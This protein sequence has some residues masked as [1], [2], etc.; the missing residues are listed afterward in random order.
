MVTQ[1]LILKVLYQ[2][3][4]RKANTSLA[5]IA[6]ILK[7]DKNSICS[8]FQD[9][10][11]FGLVDEKAMKNMGIIFDDL[12]DKEIIRVVSNGLQKKYE[13]SE[14]GLYRLINGTEN[15]DEKYY[16]SVGSPG[17]YAEE[18]VK[19]TDTLLGI[20][21]EI[22]KTENKMY[23]DVTDSSTGIDYDDILDI[24]NKK[25]I[26]N[27]LK[28]D[29]KKLESIK[30]SPYFGRM[31]LIENKSNGVEVLQLYIGNQVVKLD[32]NSII[33]DW[34]SS[35]ASY[36]YGKQLHFRL[37]D[38]KY[39]LQLKRKIDIEHSKINNIYNEL[40]K[41]KSEL[42]DTISDP[43]LLNVLKKKKDLLYFT[44]IISTIQEK[45]N[46]IIR[47]PIESNVIIQGCA[48]SGKTMI[49]LH[50]LSQILYNNKKLSVDGIK[51]IT[52]SDLFDTF[53][54]DLS[55][56]LGIENIQMLSMVQ[57]YTDHINQYYQIKKP[58]SL[59]NES[60]IDRKV[61]LEI[62]NHNFLD[63][64]NIKI[65]NV[66]QSDIDSIK[67]KKL[68]EINIKYK[69]YIDIKTEIDSLKETQLQKHLDNMQSYFVSNPSLLSKLTFDKV[70]ILE[71][72][73]NSLI[74]NN[75]VNEKKIFDLMNRI[76]ILTAKN[77]H[78]DEILNDELI[79]TLNSK[80]NSYKIKF[81]SSDKISTEQYLIEY[82]TDLIAKNREAIKNLQN[83]ITK[84]EQDKID[85]K[86]VK[87]YGDAK[88]Y[89]QQNIVPLINQIDELMLLLK[90]NEYSNYEKDVKYLDDQ[91]TLLNGY[92]ANYGE[93][94]G[95][96]TEAV[97]SLQLE[98]LYD[99]D[100][101]RY[102]EEIVI[103]EI[104]K[105]HE[106]YQSKIRFHNQFKYY[107]YLRLGVMESFNFEFKPLKLLMIDEA[108]EF[109]ISE[110]NLIK[111]IHP[112]AYLNFFG[113]INQVTSCIGLSSWDLL[114]SE[115]KY[116]ELNENYRNPKPIVSFIND[117]VEMSMIPLGIE[118]GKIYRT[119][120]S[121]NIK[122]DAV[123]F[124][125]DDKEN[126]IIKNRIPT[127]IVGVDKI[128]HID[129][130]K[131]LEFNTVLIYEEKMSRNQKYIAY[132][133][134]L[135]NLIVFE[136]DLLNE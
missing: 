47:L 117:Q 19:L 71:N 81:F 36:F 64:L 89:L 54:R 113:D 100:I 115:Y 29:I 51:I 30:S 49:L 80:A 40:T 88:K 35:I 20:D 6:C 18:N 63:M 66:M 1:D 83:E 98:L 106:K 125:D 134:A 103:P 14:Q 124:A 132:S 96:I 129:Q 78:I 3:N 34:R 25:E 95:L 119:G 87:K 21:R 46:E 11:E 24:K 42:K 93:N 107:Y 41:R 7:G 104:E 92:I 114:K 110:F 56:Q 13:I 33:L 82:R 85:I 91:I 60:I 16:S 112:N 27:S 28:S 76:D 61:L 108:Q 133:R 99:F 32:D 111:K 86:T 45:Q 67:N 43:F 121:T 116:Y 9:I 75:A 52:P 118:E 70:S 90:E 26:N 37:N 2:L 120:I 105:I 65:K 53:V 122:I 79:K 8:Q 69:K 109:S 136:D 10:K 55:Y 128:L 62:Y 131:G 57:L 22:T 68:N 31:D 94:R 126:F 39:D 74:V 12:I 4:Q 77:D 97:Q 44:D 102:F 48:G 58:V 59:K 72:E 135:E 38:S 50:R 130:A 5:M 84:L 101:N 123:L 17:D 23:K 127:D 15:D 73:L